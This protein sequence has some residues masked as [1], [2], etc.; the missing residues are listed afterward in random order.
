MRYNDPVHAT[1]TATEIAPQAHG[2][3]SL[4]RGPLASHAD[5]VFERVSPYDGDGFRNH[6]RRL[7]HLTEQLLRKDGVAMDRDVAYTVAMCHDLGLVSRDDTG[8][9]YLARSRALFDRETAGYA[10]G[11]TS[12]DVLDQCLL[13]NHRLLPVPNLAP[14]ADAFRRAVQIE[15]SHGMLRFGLEKT[16]VRKIFDNYPRGNFDRV[17]LDFTWRVLRHEP[18]TLVHGIFF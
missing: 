11:D 16:D 1:P 2:S 14:Q 7:F 4:P 5:E 18:W 6:C 12:R 9:N 13:Y 3:L 15:H 8:P 10:L 17:L